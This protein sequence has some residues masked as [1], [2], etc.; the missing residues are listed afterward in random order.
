MSTRLGIIISLKNVLILHVPW[1]LADGY[2]VEKI[3]P[4]VVDLLRLGLHDLPL[5]L[6]MWPSSDSCALNSHLDCM[7]R[8]REKGSAYRLC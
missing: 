2:A 5:L 1:T 7:S 8:V 3:P 6:H 4:A